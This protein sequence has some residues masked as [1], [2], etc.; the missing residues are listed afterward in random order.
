MEQAEIKNY[1]ILNI[2]RALFWCLLFLFHLVT[3]SFDFVSPS[4]SIEMGRNIVLASSRV[5]ENVCFFS[6]PPSK[7]LHYTVRG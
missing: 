5:W 4:L 2:N 3:R 6:L 1:S 7:T